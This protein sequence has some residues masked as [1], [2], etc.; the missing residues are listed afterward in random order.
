MLESRSLLRPDCACVVCG[1]AAFDLLYQKDIRVSTSE[2]PVF[3]RQELESC[4]RCGLVRQF[5][6]DSYCRANLDR[7]YKTTYRT[8]LTLSDLRPEDPRVENAQER[9]DF[10]ESLDA[11]R[12]L[13]EL[14][15]GDGVF[16]SLAQSR[17][18]KCSGVDPSSGYD[19]VNRELAG[20]GLD[21]VSSTFEEYADS[22][23]GRAPS[24][25]LICLFLVLEH[26]TSPVPFLDRVLTLLKPDGVLI[27]EVPDIQMYPKVT[28]ETVLTFEHVYHYSLESLEN[29]LLNLGCAL[30]EQRT[31][32]VSYG[33]S[34]ISAFRRREGV[35]QAIR[36]TGDAEYFRVF[37]EKRHEYLN[38]L[39]RV[40][41]RLN[42][43][44]EKKKV[45]VGV[46]GAGFFANV[47]VESCGLN[48]GTVDCVFDDTPEKIGTTYLG[49]KIRPIE[50]IANSGVQIL[51]ILSESFCKQMA[52]KAK[53]FAEN[54]ALE[55]CCP[56]PVAL[57]MLRAEE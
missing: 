32:G 23:A 17:S 28:S 57:S 46:Y 26:I 31:G 55:I 35:R 16:L 50:E 25:D 39:L 29:L 53:E 47:L 4:A 44:K 37:L 18:Y 14:G 2:R 11:G 48:E 8:P 15:F 24:F 40:I 38:A 36:E 20:R 21:I 22:Q 30:V 10:V 7:Y 45:E 43:R 54:E 19:Y 51:L 3:F 34:L 13:L 52:Q 49:K 27:V 42:R 56:H 5:P 9:L 41:E 6:N 12:T 33:H 1:G